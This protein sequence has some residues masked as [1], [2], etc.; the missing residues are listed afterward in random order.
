MSVQVAGP[1]ETRR[2]EGRA[3]SVLILQHEDSAPAGA[4]LD[5]LHEHDLGSTIVRGDRGEALPDPD[6][7]T[8]AVSLG[9]KSSS[10]DDPDAWIADEIEWLRRADEAGTPILGLAFGAQTL[11]RALGG[12]VQRAIRPER[13]LIHIKTNAPDAVAAGPWP[14]WHDDAIVLPPGAELLAYN[15][16]GPQAFRAGPHL[17][18][19]FHPE[20]TPAIAGRWVLEHSRG[21]LDSQGMLEGLARE[22]RTTLMNARRLFAAVIEQALAL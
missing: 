20:V 1:T 6:G 11:A 14:A 12:G 16:S 13:G 10:A 5:V 21:E 18:I 8:L 17:G 9:S 22:Q 19:Q 3:G 15:D 7:W 4:L 2:S